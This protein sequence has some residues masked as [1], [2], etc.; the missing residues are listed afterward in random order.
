MRPF[1]V[2]DVD[3]Q[4]SDV[5]RFHDNKLAINFPNILVEVF[6]ISILNFWCNCQE[7]LIG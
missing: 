4:I 5:G 1:L 2:T 6:V 3:V 7:N